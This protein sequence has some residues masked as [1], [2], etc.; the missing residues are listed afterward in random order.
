[1]EFKNQMREKIWPIASVIL[2]TLLLLSLFTF[3]QGDKSPKAGKTSGLPTPVPSQTKPAPLS[4]LTVSPE[5]F[6]WGNIKIGGGIVQMKFTLKNTST[7]A[8]SVSKLETSC[9]CTEASLKTGDKESPFF[10]M[11]GHGGANPG[12]EAEIT[13]GQEATLTVKFDPAAHGPEGLG[14][15]NRVARIW[16]S[17]PVNTYRDIA[18]TATVVK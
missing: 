5:P 14:K 1:M 13:P 2:G 4:L 15:A 7:E 17:Q 18:F 12:W 6:D 16:F 9:M 8:I 3:W 11:P 10:G